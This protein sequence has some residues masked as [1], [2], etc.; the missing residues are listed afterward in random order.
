MPP[1]PQGHTAETTGDEDLVDLLRYS[2]IFA[3]VV[4]EV[5]EIKLLREVSPEPLTLSQ[6]HLLKL[7]S[8][9][10]HHQ[11]G[12]VASFLGVSAPAASKNV[13][14][15]ERLDLV[16]RMPLEGDRRVTIIAAS[17]K[18][19]RLV[20]DYEAVKRARLGHV[21]DDF[22]AEELRQLADLLE[23]FSQALLEIEGGRSGVCLRCSAYYSADCSIRH[24]GARCPFQG[25]L[26]EVDT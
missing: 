10:G 6:F 17:D 3:S 2:H 24:L 1:L 23:R 22:T 26:E 15:L 25:I 19:R 16:R 21:L 11:V 20:A 9:N 7:I 4:R 18:G 13:D 8:L 14:K 5:L 12:Q